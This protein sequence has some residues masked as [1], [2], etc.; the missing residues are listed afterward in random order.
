MKR[1][2]MIV[3]SLMLLCAVRPAAA[4]VM[5]GGPPAPSASPATGGGGP[6]DPFVTFTFSDTSGDVGFGSV[7]TINS[8]LGDG[9]LWAVSGSLTMT[10]GVLAGD[11]FSL[12][13]AGPGVSVLASSCRTMTGSLTTWCTRRT[14]LAMA[15][16]IPVN[17]DSR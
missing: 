1:F 3:A 4:D 5:L 16:I 6:G 13:S 14:T 9:S 12:L 10:G 11:T 7:N 15:L 2:L 8:G 17:T